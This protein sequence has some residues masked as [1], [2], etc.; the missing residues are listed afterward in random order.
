MIDILKEITALALKADLRSEDYIDSKIE[1]EHLA[2]CLLMEIV[3]KM[4]NWT[5]L[6]KMQGLDT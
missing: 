2:G 6:V 3:E 4:Q 1:K 5:R